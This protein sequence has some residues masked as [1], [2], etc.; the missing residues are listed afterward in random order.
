LRGVGSAEGGVEGD[1]CGDDAGVAHLE[2]FLSHSSW[3]RCVVKEWERTKEEEFEGM[4]SKLVTWQATRQ[5]CL[6]LSSPH[7]VTPAPRPLDTLHQIHFNLNHFAKEIE[8]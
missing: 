3:W 5:G 6:A 7:H 8:S 1:E 2:R 4:W